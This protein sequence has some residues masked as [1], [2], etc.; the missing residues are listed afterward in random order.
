MESVEASEWARTG[1]CASPIIVDHLITVGR[2]TLV[3][4][5]TVEMQQKVRVVT[6]KV[7]DKQGGNGKAYYLT[8]VAREADNQVNGSQSERAFSAL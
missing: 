4:R 5:K 1:K 8:T 7:L 6:I 2:E 3:Q